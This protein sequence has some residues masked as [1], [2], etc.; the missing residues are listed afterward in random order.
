MA[1]DVWDLILV[2]KAAHLTSNGKKVGN[3]TLG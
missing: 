1:D 3:L 2:Q